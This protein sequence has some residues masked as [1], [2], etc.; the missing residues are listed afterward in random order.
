MLSI[1]IPSRNDEYLQ[2]TIDDLLNKA[3][4]EVEIIVV[5]DGYWPNPMLVHNDR[6]SIIHHGTFHDS[7]GMRHSINTGMAIARGEYV[8]K[9][10]EHCM[11]DQGYDTKLIADCEDNWM[12]VPRRYRLDAE[13]WKIIEDGRPPIDYMVIDY[14]YQR[15]YDKTCGL[16]GAE[17][18]ESYYNKSIKFF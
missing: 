8:M 3:E 9:I 4:G 5:L 7:N 6:V 13:N 10:D 15:P 14:P 2:K 16:H 11:V 12:V 1:I 17:D 18:K